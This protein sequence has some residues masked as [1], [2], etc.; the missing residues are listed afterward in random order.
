MKSMTIALLIKPAVAAAAVYGLAGVR[1]LVIRY[2][3]EGR[4]K[5]ILLLPVK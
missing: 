5:R 1:R 4:L 3:P 2:F